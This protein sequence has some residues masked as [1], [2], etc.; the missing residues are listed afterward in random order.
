MSSS[1]LKDTGPVS[2]NLKKDF[3]CDTDGVLCITAKKQYV[4]MMVTSY[5]MLF[6][7]KPN[8]KVLS[9]LEKGDHPKCND[10][11]LLDAKQTQQYQS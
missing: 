8:L 10:T 1:K 6:S 7:T 2:F 5:V 4:E 11:E 3:Y 9:L